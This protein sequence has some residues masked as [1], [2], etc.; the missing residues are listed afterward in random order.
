MSNETYI[1]DVTEQNFNEAVMQASQRVP[2]LVDFWAPWCQ[3]CK[4][5]MPVLTKLADEYGGKFILAKV[6]I[7]EQ[8]NLAQ[9]FGVRSV[10]TVKLVRNAQLADE[11][12]GAL[13]E[14]EVRAFLDKH[15]PRES[16]A[17]SQEAVALFQSGQVDEAISML[18]Q[19]W[20]DD[21]QNPRLPMQLLD[22]L[23][24][25]G[26]LDEARQVLAALPAE[27]QDSDVVVSMKARFAFMDK[28]EG[29]PDIPT[30]QQRLADND[31]DSEARY[32]LAIQLVVAGKLE[33]AM[34]QLLMLLKKD[35]QYGDDAARKTLI[36]I[37]EMLGN[38]GELVQRYRSK[39]SMLLY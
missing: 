20:Q 30:L 6:N 7:D 14:N 8:Q 23:V 11:F 25:A 37:F 24:H 17:A 36:Q 10:P 3:P 1:V 13:P 27:Q 33:A 28:A 39:M 35:R 32:Q 12:M 21:P 38:Q 31:D 5:L 9:H 4:S 2:V 34:D 19:A 26:R 22:L 15:I 29:L 18:N 16:D